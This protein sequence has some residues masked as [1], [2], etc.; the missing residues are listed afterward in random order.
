MSNYTQ[1]KN[2]NIVFNNY[3]KPP[4]IISIQIVCNNPIS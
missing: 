4:F 3:I 2:N 1:T